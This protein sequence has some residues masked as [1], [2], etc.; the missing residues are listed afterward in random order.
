MPR[1]RYLKQSLGSLYSQIHESKILVVGAGGIGCELLKNLVTT[2]FGNIHIVDLD[3][4]DLS[5]LNRQ[6]LFR[7]AHIKKSKALVAKE[8]ASKFN[9][10]VNITALHANIKDPKFNV[11]WFKDFAIVFNALDNL[12][13]RRHV[14][15]MCIAAD[16]PLIESGTTGFKGQVQPIRKGLTQCYDC[17]PKETPKSFPVCTIRSTP[18]QPIHCIVWAKSY[19]FSE[20]FGI[21][22]EESADLDHTEDSDNTEEIKNLRKEAAALKEIRQ[23]M[24]SEEFPQRVFD[25]VFTEDIKRLQGMEDMWKSRKMPQALEFADLVKEAA[26]ASPTIA[27]EDQR[28]WNV[29]ENVAVFTSSLNRLSNRLEELRANAETGNAPPILSFDKDDKDTLDFVAAAANLRSIIFHIEV[30]SEFDI[31]QM[32]GNIIPAIATTNATTAA[33]CVLEAFKVM[34]GNYQKAK[35]VFLSKSLDRMVDT[36]AL[37]AP[38]GA[39]PVCQNAQAKLF[40]DPSRARLDSLV[41]GVLNAKLNYSE[42]VSVYTEAGLIYDIDEEDNLSKTFSEL[43]I[44]KD[45]SITII[46]HADENAKVNLILHIF[47][48]V[49]SD[50][51][52]NMRLDPNDLSVPVKAK[53]AG[54]EAT[55]NG[56][57]V[58]EPPN[59]GMKRKRVDDEAELDAENVRK[60]GKV[61]E[62][63]GGDANGGANGDGA[64]AVE[65]TEGAIV[66]D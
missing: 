12:D 65:D 54:G 6:F 35:M 33:L 4:I 58:V 36:E 18:S 21:S 24:G 23:A 50:P 61:P 30:K 66:L 19:L 20:L 43:G 64:I 29:A 22:E 16:V 49:N 44:G 11:D 63:A 15:K 57:S 59:S 62:Q 47:E 53:P 41:N 3:T 13:A 34:Q 17:T 8:T 26:Q 42:E 48:E 55:S 56:A 46:D 2:G 39:C 7:H 1:D 10:N 32:A 60:R 38:D 28:T 5:N 31:K 37:R 25:K 51:T 9:P 40:V 14:N 45:A 52:E 27:D